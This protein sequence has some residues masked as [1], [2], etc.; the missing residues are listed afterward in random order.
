GYDIPGQYSALSP[1]DV[2]RSME[3]SLF[4]HHSRR[5]I[6]LFDPDNCSDRSVARATFRGR[7]LQ[8]QQTVCLHRRRV[9]L[10]CVVLWFY[11]GRRR[12]VS[13]VA[14]ASV[15]RTGG[16]FSLLFDDSR[17]RD[18]RQSK[19]RQSRDATRLRIN[20]APAARYV[21]SWRGV[22][23]SRRAFSS[24]LGALACGR[25]VVASASAVPSPDFP[26][27]PLAMHEQAMRLAIVAAQANPAWPFGA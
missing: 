8:S 24:S 16:G 2:S 13:D 17:G 19:R 26:A 27:T 1:S 3:R 6:D 23:W 5:G 4:A 12:M 18:L 20:S 10:S 11:G 9:R 15:E 21:S 7:V 22:M 25:A 14:V